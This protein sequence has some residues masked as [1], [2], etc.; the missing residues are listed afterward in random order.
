ME[1]EGARWGEMR[2]ATH[3]VSTAVPRVSRLQ[4]IAAV[5]GGLSEGRARGEREK[6]AWWL[7][8]VVKVLFFPIAGS[9]RASYSGLSIEF[10]VVS[11]FRCE[12]IYIYFYKLSY[13]LVWS[14]KGGIGGVKTQST[15]SGGV[16]LGS[17]SLK[18]SSGHN[19]RN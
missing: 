1:P 13:T 18:Q 14:Q 12:N 2:V 6:F 8:T 19:G 4:S 15:H 7:A 16:R 3:P 10:T 5:Y 11:S 9:W 17:L